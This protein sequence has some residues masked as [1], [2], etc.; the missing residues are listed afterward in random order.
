MKKKYISK[1]LFISTILLGITSCATRY[2]KQGVMPTGKS[3]LTRKQI[4][5]DFTN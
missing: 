1:L 5:R 4:R 3:E 2:Y